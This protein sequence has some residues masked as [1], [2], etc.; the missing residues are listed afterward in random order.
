MSFLTDEQKLEI[1]VVGTVLP[2]KTD[3]YVV[4]ELID[5]SNFE[6]DPFFHLTFPQRE[7]LHEKD[8]NRIASLI[9]T[10]ASKELVKEEVNRIRLK[11]NPNPAGQENNVPVL[12]ENV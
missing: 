8:F 10:N 12:K 7:M 2:F 11:L 5:W 1:E 4:D 6:K 9:K 3:N